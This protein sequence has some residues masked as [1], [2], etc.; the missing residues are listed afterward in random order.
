MSATKPVVQTTLI[1]LRPEKDR[2]DP[3]D[4]VGEHPTCI[5]A[6]STKTRTVKPTRQ[7][8]FILAPDP[9]CFT[10]HHP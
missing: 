2:L 1:G 4:E 10:A 9:R 3:E 8:T 6:D 7:F 5:P